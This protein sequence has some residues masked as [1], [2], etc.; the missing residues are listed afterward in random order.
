MTRRLWGVLA[1][2]VWG[3]ASTASA[4]FVDL[5]PS[6]DQWIRSTSGTSSFTSDAISVRDA[7][8]SG[9]ARWGIVQFDLSGTGFT[10]ADLLGASLMLN[11]R[12]N[13]NDAGQSASLID[14]TNGTQALDSITWD[15]Y[16]IDHA[17]SE[18]ALGSLGYV[19]PLSAFSGGAVVTTSAN[20]SDLAAIA[21]TIDGAS[22]SLLTLVFAPNSATT[23]VDWT[24]GPGQLD[25]LPSVLRLEFPGDPPPPAPCINCDVPLGDAVWLRNGSA[26]H[27]DG[28]LVTNNPEVIGNAPTVGLVQWDLSEV[29][30]DPARL[31][32]A[33]L[34]FTVAET[35]R[36]QNPGQVAGLIDTTGGTALADI[37]DSAG[38]AAEYLGTEQPLEGLGVVPDTTGA[39]L[40][41]ETFTT[42]ATAAD[43]QLIREVLNGSGLLT[44]ALFGSDIA[45]PDG[46]TGQ[47]W[48][49]GRYGAAPVLSLTFSV[50]EP[51]TSVM[52][53]LS[54]LSCAVCLVRRK[55]KS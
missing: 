45:A 52:M 37:T 47:Y 17:G 34:T 10:G 4:I 16:Q 38:Y 51:G 26:H 29:P 15:Q 44:M 39:L 19:A 20:A 55:A 33:Q 13:A 31:V 27:N 11:V 21:S 40:A 2:V 6:G 43:L 23:N 18:V 42:T 48:G 1:T 54:A 32:S 46:V 22:G 5:T 41:G 14:I 7:S 9:D 49:D 53:S 28:V 25:N 36:T 8:V 3:V 12:S 50:P 30:D 35:S 24:D